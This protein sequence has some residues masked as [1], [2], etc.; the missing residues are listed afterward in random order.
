MTLI[1]YGGAPP[2]FKAM[3]DKERPIAERFRAA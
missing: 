2:S 1:V 3:L